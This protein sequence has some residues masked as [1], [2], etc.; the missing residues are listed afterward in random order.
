MD[1]R[2][3]G[4]EQFRDLALRLKTADKA[5]MGELRK[6]VAAAVRPLGEAVKAEIPAT[7]P[8]GYAPTLSRSV[9]N[10]VT[11]R[12]SGANFGVSFTTWAAGKSQRRKVSALNRGTLRHP[13]FGNRNRWYATR[14]RPGFW[15]RPVEDGKDAAVR[16]AVKA[17]DQVAAKIA[18]G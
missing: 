14:V 16:G 12:A 4:A 9:R 3:R 8:G 15:S 1:L 11:S 17:M 6:G 2:V 18:G 5:M 13:L 10:R 7:M